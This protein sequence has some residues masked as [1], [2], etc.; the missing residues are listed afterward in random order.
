MTKG[1]MDKPIEDL[2]FAQKKGFVSDV[3]RRP[4]SFLI[5]KVTN[6]SKPDRRPRRSEGRNSGAHHPDQNGAQGAR[7]SD[8][9]RR[10]RSWK[11]RKLRG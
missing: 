10:T 6:A 9:A 1:L 7:V 8:H 3:I 5:L 4:N 2:V 11:S